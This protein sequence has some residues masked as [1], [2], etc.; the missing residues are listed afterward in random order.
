MKQPLSLEAGAELGISR[1]SKVLV[2]TA[3]R[4]SAG[5]FGLAILA[6]AAR[7][8][9]LAAFASFRQV[10]ICYTLALPLLQLGVGQ[11]LFYV[12]PR[13]K[14]R[15]RGRVS[16]LIFS[17]IASGSIYAAFLLLGGNHVLAKQFN[18]PDLAQLLPLLVPC[19]IFALPATQ[20]TSV[21]IVRDKVVSAS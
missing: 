19:L 8:L 12:L 18:N 17:L 9:D 16:D 13:E 3:S 6:I 21:L 20:A 4:G 1:T 11:G 15:P 7:Q 10:L 2:L 5:V 14:S